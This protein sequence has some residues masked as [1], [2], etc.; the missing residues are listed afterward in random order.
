MTRCYFTG[1]AFLPDEGYVLNRQKAHYLLHDLKS[2]ADSLEHLIEQLAPVDVEP[3]VQAASQGLNPRKR[4]RLVCKAVAETLA[5]AYPEISLFRPWSEYVAGARL[6]KWKCLREHPLYGAGIK[7]L[8]DE[9]LL[10][11]TALGNRVL[12]LLA[13][14]Q[15]LP[16]RTCVAIKAGVCVRNHAMPAE[17][18]VRRLRTAI[19]EGHGLEDLGVPASEQE[20]V[21]ANLDDVT[22]KSDAPANNHSLSY[23][24]VHS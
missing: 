8:T 17:E 1:V 2:R 4:H 10:T 22:L 23:D 18:I 9:D 19:F 3:E 12:Y 14:R 7:A 5:S 21:A 15:R 11:V 24:A 20:Y 6:F 16:Q 13:T